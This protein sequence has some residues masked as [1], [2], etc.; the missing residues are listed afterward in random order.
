MLLRVSRVEVRTAASLG[1]V[2]ALPLRHRCLLGGMLGVL[3]GPLLLLA[4][5][6]D[7][8]QDILMACLPLCG[9]AT[10]LAL[11]ADRNKLS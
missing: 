3:R 6:E 9:G 8:T 4:L 5:C 2:E 1:Y 7:E 11:C 10:H